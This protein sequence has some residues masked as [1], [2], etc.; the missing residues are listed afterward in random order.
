MIY[1]NINLRET[2]SFARIFFYLPL[3]FRVCKSVVQRREIMALLFRKPSIIALTIPK[4]F[5]AD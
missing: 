3:L 5:V 2:F 4:S 1:Q